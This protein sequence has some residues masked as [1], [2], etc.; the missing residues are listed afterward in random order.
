MSD[1]GMN[2][3]RLLKRLEYLLGK[4][5]IGIDII[6]SRFNI[7][8]IDPAWKRIY[9]E[10]A[11]QKCYR[12]FMGRKKVCPNCGIVNAL[13]TKKIL[14]SEETL[15]KEGN[16]P[17]Q[18]TTIPFKDENGEWLVAETNVDIS[19]IKATEEKLRESEQKYKLLFE[20]SNDAIFIADA[21]TRRLVDCNKK[22]RI[23][24]G[25]S[26][27]EVLS[28]RADQLHPKDI[29]RKTMKGF[30]DQ[31]RGNIKIVDSQ[32]LTRD[33]RKIDVSISAAVLNIQGKTYLLGVFRDI[34]EHKKYEEILSRDN[35]VLEEIVAERSR[36]LL[37]TQ[38]ELDKA[39]H[40]SGLGLLAAT[41]AHEL[42]TP[43]AAIRTAVYN[44]DKK[45]KDP[46][47]DS[48]VNS[49]EN[50]VAESD[51][52]IKNLLAYSR[53]KPPHYQ[54][55]NVCEL[56][57]E[58][59]AGLKDMFGDYNVLV[60]KKLLRSDRC[61]IEADPLQLKEVFNNILRNAYESF[62]SKK[63]KLSIMMQSRG[64]Y[65]KIIF[66]DNGCGIAKEHISKVCEPF[67]T[68]KSKGIGLGLA[69]CRQI[70]ELHKG[71]LEIG[72]ARPKGTIVT[73]IL[74]LKWVPAVQIVEKSRIK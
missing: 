60:Y 24:T 62:A 43:L 12:Y 52:I 69:I 3:S 73:M 34:T 2:A 68:T 55:V 14:V 37:R 74:P 13:K 59:V 54:T 7:R 47:I 33:G 31:V 11:G 1:K 6:D 65:L 20:E 49:I 44:I 53:L 41:V 42:R 36:E 72:R 21:R 22:A 63:G 39:K 10:P 48:H 18:V 29:V 61:C 17:I 67:F 26:K 32:L 50:K 66:R 70:L 23:V 71:R 27:D 19:K 58:C 46:A 9:G 15:I 45:C 25:Y 5:K 51:Q 30:K 38:E 40:L 4:S 16:R 8:Y 56:I 28:M 64:S 57:E 35:K